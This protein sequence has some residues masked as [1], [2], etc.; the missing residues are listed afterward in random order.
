MASPKEIIKCTKCQTKWN[1]PKI[2][3]KLKVKCKN[4]ENSFYNNIQI[5]CPECNNSCRVP[6]GLGKLKVTCNKCDN[7]FYFNPESINEDSLVSSGDMNDIEDHLSGTNERQ[8]NDSSEKEEIEKLIRKAEKLQDEEDFINAFIAW[9]DVVTE[10]DIIIQQSKASRMLA[11]GAGFAGALLT[12]GI[13]LEDIVLVPLISQGLMKLFG[14]DLKDFLKQLEYSLTKRQY[15]MHYSD[16]IVLIS[17]FH[18]ELTYFCWCYEISN[19][20]ED[21]SKLKKLLGLINPF[22]D[23]Q[24]LKHKKSIVELYDLIEKNISE[25]YHAKRFQIDKLNSYLFQYLK[26]SN[27][28]NNDL[29]KKL[30]TMTRQS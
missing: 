2:D 12:G 30:F 16:D 10:L 17:D 19:E 20:V 1:V 26:K 15:C 23:T 29:Y 27:K 13:G 9:D 5:D 18:K 3:R 4:C 6:N 28:K 8:S 14:I 7:I 21:D 22:E 25:S 24:S 11:K